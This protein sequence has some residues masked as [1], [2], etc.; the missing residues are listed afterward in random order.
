MHD[1]ACVSQT[2]AMAA[3]PGIKFAP[4]TVTVPP[5]YMR[6]GDMEF[7]VVLTVLLVEPAFEE[8]V[9]FDAAA[10]V[11]LEVFDGTAGSTGSGAPGIA[12]ICKTLG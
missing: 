5:A 11:V 3:I 4:I 8:P 9:L 6:C 2:V 7:D 10:V 12:I 1:D